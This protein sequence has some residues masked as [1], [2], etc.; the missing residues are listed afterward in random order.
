MH[1]LA[2]RRKPRSKVEDLIRTGSSLTLPNA[3]GQTALDLALN[4]ETKEQLLR[5][6]T[7]ASAACIIS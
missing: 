2:L 4:D 1:I 7:D 6:A 5:G 3:A